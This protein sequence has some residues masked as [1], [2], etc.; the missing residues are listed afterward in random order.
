MKKIILLSLMALMGLTGFSQR[1]KVVTFNQ[2]NQYKKHFSSSI[3]GGLENNLP[4]QFVAGNTT[5]WGLYS[6]EI[7]GRKINR[8]HFL[9]GRTFKPVNLSANVQLTDFTIYPTS[10]FQYGAGTGV[11][12]PNGVTGMGYPFLGIYDKATMT[13]ISA[14]YFYLSYPGITSPANAIGLQIKYSKLNNSFYI[15]GVMA[16]RLFADVNMDNIRGKSKGFIMKIDASGVIGPRVLVFDPDALPDP[17]DP[18]LCLVTDLEMNANE[19]SIAFTGMTTVAAYSNYYSPMVG[20]ID[21]NLNLQWCYAYEFSS[22]R[23]SG[24]DVEYDIP[25]N[26]L[27][28]LLNASQY[29]FA[30]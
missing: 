25:D 9:E 13:V 2:P 23:Y 1:F 28:V 14:E 26:S 4:R 20:M 5:D 22:D 15:S 11:Y 29:P 7:T 18:L 24:I 10:D 12:Y 19:T 30:V 16:D 27:L 6:K 8:T 3:Q 17:K 21:M